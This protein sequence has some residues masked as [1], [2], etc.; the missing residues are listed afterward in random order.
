MSHVRL[1][2]DFFH[3]ELVSKPNNQRLSLL[4]F[5]STRPEFSLILPSGDV[6]VSRLESGGVYEIWTETFRRSSPYQPTTKIYQRFLLSSFVLPPKPP[7]QLG[8]FVNDQNSLHISWVK[9]SDSH[10]DSFRVHLVNNES[11]TTQLTK[12]NF[13]TINDLNRTNYL[14]SVVTLFHINSTFSLVSQPIQLNFTFEHR[15][16]KVLNAEPIEWDTQS[17]AAQV[18][19]TWSLNPIEICDLAS[20]RIQY[21]NSGIEI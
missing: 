12:D 6:N 21:R 10:F 7:S 8:V 17:T 9:P 11:F 20:F 15:P 18:K 13:L 14:I 1:V 19:L 2:N 4:N 3:I 5:T 16:I